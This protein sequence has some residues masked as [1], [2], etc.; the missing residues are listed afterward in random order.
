MLK[1]LHSEYYLSTYI[2]IYSFLIRLYVYSTY[3][4][5]SVYLVEEDL[6][7]PSVHYFRHV[8][9][10]SRTPSVFLAGWMASS[11]ERI[12]GGI[13]T[14]RKWGGSGLKINNLNNSA[15]EGI[16]TISTCIIHL[17]NQ[18]AYL[19]KEISSP[20]SCCRIKIVARSTCTSKIS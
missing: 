13:R 16:C 9:L 7:F 18:L 5:I 3:G 17:Y 1:R 14:E 11:H 12:P 10:L 2:V 4:D 20:W 6:W 19:V 8:G 15:T